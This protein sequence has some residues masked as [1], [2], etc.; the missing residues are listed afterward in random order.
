MIPLV[1]SRICSSGTESFFEADQ[2]GS[3][4]ENR[5]WNSRRSGGY[6]E[7]PLQ[8]VYPVNGQQG[9]L[10]SIGV[11]PDKDTRPNW[12]FLGTSARGAQE[13]SQEHFR[14]SSFLR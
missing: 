2:V 11:E 8:I 6:Y 1:V 5:D 13:K 7:I 4:G 12:H 9:I 3:Q 14:L 10:A